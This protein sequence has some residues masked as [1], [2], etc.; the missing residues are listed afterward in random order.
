M[1]SFTPSYTA[2]TVLVKD[3]LNSLSSDEITL[4]VTTFFIFGDSVDI[5]IL[6]QNSG[7]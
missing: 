2:Q 1:S 4:E 3:T 6:N 5:M 7:Y